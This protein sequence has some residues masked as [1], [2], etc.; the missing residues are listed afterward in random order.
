MAPLIA[1]V[2][3]AVVVFLFGVIKPSQ[4]LLGTFASGLLVGGS[5]SNLA[6]GCSAP[7]AER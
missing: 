4:S 7:M 2:G 3:V 6:I 5:V 1:L